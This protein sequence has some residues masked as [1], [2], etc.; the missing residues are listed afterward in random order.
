M[1]TCTAPIF[2]FVIHALQIH[3]KDYDDDI[4]ELKDS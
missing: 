2:S 4:D 1:D 3:N